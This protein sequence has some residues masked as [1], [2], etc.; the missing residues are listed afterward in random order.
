MIVDPAR[1]GVP[2]AVARD[3]KPREARYNTILLVARLLHDGREDLCRIRNVSAGGMLIEGCVALAVGT[4]IEVELRN[5]QSA[6]AT[7]A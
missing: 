2:T 6:E 1:P 5:L 4:R 3:L 7:V